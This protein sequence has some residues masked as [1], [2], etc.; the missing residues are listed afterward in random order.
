MFLVVYESL[1]GN[2]R[3]VAEAIAAGLAA[4]GE[5]RA[6]SVGEAIERGLAD[7][8]LLVVGTPTHAWGLPR[9]RT[10][11]PKGYAAPASPKPA[12]LVRNWLATLPAGGG[13][14][15]A[16]FSTR[17]GK[18]RLLTGS[19]APG[20]ARRLRHHGWA[21]AAAPASFVVGGTEGPLGPGEH[22]RARAWGADLARAVAR[23]PAQPGQHGAMDQT[24]KTARSVD[25][26]R[27]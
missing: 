9:E 20:I 27:H 25:S 6:V 8:E 18:A 4:A 19:A 26:A 16:A 21:Q 12:T 10:W 14:P 7:V 1:Y 17:L 3:A 5:A 23:R 24:D 11:A 15:A 22:D 2:T 13:K